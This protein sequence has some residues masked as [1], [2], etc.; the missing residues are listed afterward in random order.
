MT[1]TTNGDDYGGSLTTQDISK[2]CAKMICKVIEGWLVGPDGP[3][4]AKWRHTGRCTCLDARRRSVGCLCDKHVCVVGTDSGVQGGGDGECMMNEEEKR[5][6]R[7][8]KE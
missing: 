7:R 1:L 6:E 5:K 4:C 2:G 8:K 3:R